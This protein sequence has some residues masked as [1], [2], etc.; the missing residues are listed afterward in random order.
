MDQHAIALGS[1][2]RVRH[3]L[4]PDLHSGIWI[5]AATFETKLKKCEKRISLNNLEFP[6]KLGLVV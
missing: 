1:W 4:D 3:S 5:Q 6:K 2:I